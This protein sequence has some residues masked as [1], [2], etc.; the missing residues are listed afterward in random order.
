MER[1]SSDHV[2]FCPLQSH[3]GQRLCTAYGAPN[4]ISTA[5]LIDEGTILTESSAILT[6]FAWMGFPWALLGFMA[7]CIPMCIRDV[8]YRIFARN[9]GAIWKGVK[10]VTCLGDVQ[11]EVY[12]NRML[13][14]SSMP[15]P[16]P[17]SW[18]FE[19]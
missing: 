5:V 9:R 13:G 17:Q 7:L 18:G 4:D 11:M 3:L 19:N 6:L 12:R 14:L 8:G 15:R 2:R 10:R 16:L 1:D